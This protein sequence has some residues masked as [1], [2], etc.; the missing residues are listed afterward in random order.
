MSNSKHLSDAQTSSNDN[1]F[2]RAVSQTQELA[3]AYCPGLQAL[4]DNAAYILPDQPQLLDGS[5]DIDKSVQKLYPEEP[6]WDYVI[7]YQQRAYFV[8]IHPA[9]SDSIADITKKAQWLRQW[10]QAKAPLLRD[11]SASNELYWIPS[12]RCAIAPK[13]KQAKLLAQLKIK[14]VARPMRL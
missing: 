4:K 2:K 14:I 11:M 1:E 10:L 3:D 12:G 7:G 6:R 13:S 8:E 9:G 5:V